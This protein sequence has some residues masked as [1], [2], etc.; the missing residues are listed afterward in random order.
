MDNSKKV[1]K[2]TI[3]VFSYI[4]LMWLPGMAEAQTSISAATASLQLASIYKAYDSMRY[5]SFDIRIVMDTDT[6][7]GQSMQNERYGEIYRCRKKI[8]LYHG[9]QRGDAKRFVLGFNVQNR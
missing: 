1:L 4:T 6:L 2:K 3:I 5:V 9:R 8:P 7:N